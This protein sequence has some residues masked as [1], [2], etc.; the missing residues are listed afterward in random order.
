MYD[1]WLDRAITAPDER[2]GVIADGDAVRGFVTV[3]LGDRSEIGLIGATADGSG[4]GRALLA[5]AASQIPVGSS[6]DV[7]TQRDNSRA[8]RLYEAN[9]FVALSE[10]LVYH[11]WLND[12]GR[13]G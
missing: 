13:H 6:L 1:A 7:A 10:S 4:A 12:N 5:W 11:L 2:V 8:L 3:R 9:G